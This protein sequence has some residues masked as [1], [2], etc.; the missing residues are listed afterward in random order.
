MVK[1]TFKPVVLCKV[2][3]QEHTKISKNVYSSRDDLH[4][5]LVYERTCFTLT[6]NLEQEFLCYEITDFLF[7]SSQVF[8]RS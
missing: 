7:L 3:S 6:Q 1:F 2:D 5:D 8:L 4:E